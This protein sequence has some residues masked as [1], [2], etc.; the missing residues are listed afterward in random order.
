MAMRCL[1]AA[2]VVH[3]CAAH[4]LTITG[5]GYVRFDSDELH[6]FSVGLDEK[7]SRT[8]ALADHLLPTWDGVPFERALLWI[9]ERGIWCDHS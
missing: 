9:R 8:I 5:N 4:G 7:A 3:W 6:C 2:E 1:T